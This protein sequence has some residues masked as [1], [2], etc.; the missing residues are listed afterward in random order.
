MMRTPGMP[1][2]AAYDR[3]RDLRG[4]RSITHPQAKPVI[5]ARTTNKPPRSGRILT[6]DF[7]TI[8]VDVDVVVVVV[9]LVC[10]CVMIFVTVVLTVLVIVM[11]DVVL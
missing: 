6:T 3:S 5:T 9:A 8:D 11:Y 7:G 10:V 1:R 2:M 4:E